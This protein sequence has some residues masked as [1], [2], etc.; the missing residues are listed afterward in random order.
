MTAHK[1]VDRT[2]DYKLAVEPRL[3]NTRDM[4]TPERTAPVKAQH[5]PVLAMDLCAHCRLILGQV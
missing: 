1:H 4:R 5:I 2:T 3:R